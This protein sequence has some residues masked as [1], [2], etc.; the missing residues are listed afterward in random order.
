MS[1]Y[2]QDPNN[3]KKQVPNVIGTGTA[4]YSYATCPATQTIVK[5]PS[6]VTVNVEGTYAF[7]YES[8]SVSTYI[9][10]S[11]VEAAAGGIKLDISPVAWTE[12][13]SNTGTVGDITFVYVRVR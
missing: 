6:Y 10:G 3:S 1:F 2:K 12:I 4:R 11:V 8:G 7:A 13:G 9:T 5:R